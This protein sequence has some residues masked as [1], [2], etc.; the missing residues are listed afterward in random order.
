MAR[1][2]SQQSSPQEY[3]DSY[4][5]VL[6]LLRERVTAQDARVSALDAKANG[7][8]TIATTIL[9]TALV[10]QAALVA[11]SSSRTIILDLARLQWVIFALVIIYLLTMIAATVSGYWLRK[12]N[13]APEPKRLKDYALKPK[14]ETKSFLVGTMTDTF[15]TNERIILSK[16]WGMRI[17]TIGLLGEILMLGVLLF[18]QTHG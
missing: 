7:I 18:L 16:V 11:I 8:M 15:N 17:A 3:D 13:R 2:H 9:G 1:G 5:L 4:D 10:L 6:D 14:A 12:F